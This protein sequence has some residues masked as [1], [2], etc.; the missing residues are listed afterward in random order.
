MKT[1]DQLIDAVHK[2]LINVESS[3]TR[4]NNNI[5][6]PQRT[7]NQQQ[8]QPEDLEEGNPKV[9][10]L[11][12]LTYRYEW[13]L[14]RL[15]ELPED[16][17]NPFT[18][19]INSEYVRMKEES[20]REIK[21]YEEYIAVAKENAAKAGVSSEEMD[22][23]AKQCKEFYLEDWKKYEEYQKKVK[24]IVSKDG[25]TEID[26]NTGKVRKFDIY[27]EEEIPVV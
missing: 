15:A 22:K 20:E 18:G 7:N 23:F 16:F 6:S 12:R 25:V 11:G 5:D 17:T 21:E 10:E 4:I 1:I 2:K 9:L 19:D 27:L 13:N 24:W 14:G 26:G 8:Q 3:R